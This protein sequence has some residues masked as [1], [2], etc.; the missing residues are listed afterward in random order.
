M[1]FIVSYQTFFKWQIGTFLFMMLGYSI[2]MGVEQT[3]LNLTGQSIINIITLIK[4]P[5]EY[6]IIFVVIL[7][8]TLTEIKARS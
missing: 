3:L 1:R 4:R 2:I 6:L 8:Y 5:L 7:I